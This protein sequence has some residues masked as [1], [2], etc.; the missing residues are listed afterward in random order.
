VVTVL[1]EV[2]DEPGRFRAGPGELLA[3]FGGLDVLA[4]TERDGEASLVALHTR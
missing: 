1:S 2:G 4:H 3:A